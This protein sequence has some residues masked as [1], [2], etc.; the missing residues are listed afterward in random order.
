MALAQRRDQ[1]ALADARGPGDDE[2]HG[3][4]VMPA[5]ATTAHS[6]PAGSAVQHRDELGALALG[7]P[8]D[9]LARRDAAVRE[10][11]VHFD[12][13]VLGDGQQHVEDLRGLEVFRRV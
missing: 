13:A 8:A 7:E 10:D 11:L 2:Y 6:A 4:T 3:P 5:A 1:G 12:A 9:R